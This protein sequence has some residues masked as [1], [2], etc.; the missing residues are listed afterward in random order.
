MTTR[1]FSERSTAT[2]RR[3]FAKFSSV[4][5]APSMLTMKVFSRNRGMYW[6]MPRRSVSFMA[7]RYGNLYGEIRRGDKRSSTFPGENVFQRTETS[8]VFLLGAHGNTDEFR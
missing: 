8:L 4:T 3:M 1:M 5:T 7:H 2:S 6:R